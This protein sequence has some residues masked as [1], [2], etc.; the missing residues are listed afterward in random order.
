MRQGADLLTVGM[1]SGAKRRE[2]LCL[3]SH[4]DVELVVCE[5]AVPLADLVEYMTGL[6]PKPSPFEK[7]PE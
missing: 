1:T 5:H 7:P 2:M 4:G 6:F 3:R